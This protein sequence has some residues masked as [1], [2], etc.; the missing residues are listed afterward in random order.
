MFLL[1][2]GY[3]LRVVQLLIPFMCRSYLFI[4]IRHEQKIGYFLAE[5]VATSLYIL[6][7]NIDLWDD[8]CIPRGAHVYAIHWQFVVFCFVVI[9]LL[10]LRR[11][12]WFIYSHSSGLQQL[13]LP[14][15]QPRRIWVKSGNKPPQRNR[16]GCIIFGTYVV[17]HAI[18]SFRI[19]GS[20]ILTGMYVI[21]NTIVSFH[22]HRSSNFINLFYCLYTA[23]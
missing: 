10:V 16:T 22:I 12:A 2:K 20:C 7:T 13:P 9:V 21:Y 8:L 6:Q 19:H 4:F 15:C 1:S 17:Y 3:I 5:Q 23:W 18:V 14:L 11:R